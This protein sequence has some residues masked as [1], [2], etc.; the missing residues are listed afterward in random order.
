VEN[1]AHR[2]DG[3]ARVTGSAVKDGAGP[4]SNG[5]AADSGDTAAATEPATSADWVHRPWRRVV[6][7]LSGEAFSGDEPLG[8]S[9]RVVERIAKEIVAVV[10]DGVQV[11]AVVG[12]GN[13]FRG[14]ELAESGFDR[15]RAD[16]MGMLG[17]VINCL[18]L[19]DVLERL[20]VDTR[21]QTA[22]TMGQVA[23][24]YIPRRA[25]RHLEKGRIVIF[26]AGL[27]AP[28]F[29]TDTSAAQR[30]L[31]IGA[32]ALL[33]GTQVD[34]VYDADPRLMPDA[35]RFHQLDYSD[36]LRLGLK[37]MDTTAVSLCMDNGLPIVVFDLMEEGN[38]V[39]AVRGERIGTLI[40]RPADAG[41]RG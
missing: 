33:K 9:P 29:S 17:T 30:A 21:V 3:A 6:V 32:E 37:F 8:I 26:G 40:S 16:Y 15:A 36:V 38:V 23:E 12:G 24:P 35:V 25:I 27:G 11:A 28:F 5:H 34:G 4:V 2:E 13:M 18:A 31:E 22:I 10:E 41:A 39:R 7:K 1:S 19:Q 20:G 14:R